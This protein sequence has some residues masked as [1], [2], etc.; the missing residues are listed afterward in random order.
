M[1][2][3]QEGI[4]EQHE[5]AVRLVREGM[6]C[7]TSKSSQEI[8]L[9]NKLQPM[10]EIKNNHG[11]DK[12]A[13]YEPFWTT[14]G[15]A[16]VSRLQ[17]LVR[18][19]YNMTY[20]TTKGLGGGGG[21][22]NTSSANSKKNSAATSSTASKTRAAARPQYTEKDIASKTNLWDPANAALHNVSIVR[23]SHDAWG[24]HKIILLFCDDFVQR[25]YA[26][27]WWHN[28]DDIREAMQPILTV[29]NVDASRVVRL[30][31]ASLPP[32]VTIPVHED[33]GAWV[34]LTH[35]VH[36]PIIVEQVDNILFRCGGT[37]ETMERI[38]T[39]PGHVFEMN[40]QAKHA[41]SNCSNDYRVHAILD[42]VDPEYAA[43]LP[44]QINLDPAEILVQTRRSI[45]RIKDQGMRPTPSYMILGAQKAGTTS[46][47]E[48]M[49]QH[50]LIVRSRRRETHCLDWRWNSSL[51]T[52]SEQRKWC[53]QAYFK[54]ELSQHP[55]CLTGDSTPSYLIDSR[56]VIQRLK[57]VFPWPMKFFVMLRNPVKRAESHFAMVTS[58]KGT[59]AQLKTRGF[60]WRDKS[61][62]DV[63]MEDLQNMRQCG[64]I[65]YWNIATGELD[66][67]LFDSFSGTDK[68]NHAWDLYLKDIP[69]NTGSY[70][71]LGRGMYELNLR[72]WLANF[73]KHD[74]LVLP[75]ERFESDGVSSIMEKVWRHVGLPSYQVDDE[76][77][78]NTRSYDSMMDQ[79]LYNY[80]NRFFE[81]HNRRLET[82]LGDEWRDIWMD[83]EVEN[84]PQ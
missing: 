3:S 51:T 63:V 66:Q 32:G 81:P 11:V 24:I 23:P 74:F 25:R 53:H 17:E 82:L 59:P 40:N 6:V 28:R 72:P 64:L 56:R 19:G 61:F 52:A 10:H 1:A 70:S 77:A 67:A 69:L 55:S 20:K 38:S 73:A 68:E 9:T 41:V 12:L 42:Y 37:V 58:P 29:L 62:K 76:S 31:L 35:R 46:L 54:E 14:R 79:D 26:L 16:D 43:S 48:Y 15:R 71:L 8:P 84:F 78:K 5:E 39:T 80:L 60:E 49:I 65:P 36:V 30:L 21:N 44:P 47:Y 33:S 34:G 18:E 22:R 7:S 50:P 2:T 83:K 57:A 45:D 4:K 27:P 75:L 13:Q